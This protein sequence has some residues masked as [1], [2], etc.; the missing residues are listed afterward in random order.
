[1]KTYGR[2]VYWMENDNDMVKS[3]QNKTEQKEK[4]Q[5]KPKKKKGRVIKIV[6]AVILAW[7]IVLLI[8][9]TVPPA[10]QPTAD[11]ADL[12]VLTGGDP[13][14]RVLSVDD[15]RDALI[16][17]LRM[18]ENAEKTLDLS[19][20]GFVDD[21]S[22]QDVMSALQAAAERGVKIRLLADGSNYQLDRSTRFRT[23]AASPNIDVRIYNPINIIIKPWQ[24]NYRM[25]DKYLIADRAGSGPGYS[26]LLPQSG[27][28]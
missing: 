18:I 12:P 15:N 22:G 20:F 17:R 25:H 23:L 3:V 26:G 27:R 19:Y 5:I 28:K 8:C 14:E 21:E 13:Q 4:K 11:P 2:G 24:V 9:G 6:T 16:W 1:M 10:F 7:L